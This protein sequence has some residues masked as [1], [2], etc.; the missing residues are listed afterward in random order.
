[1]FCCVDSKLFFDLISELRKKIVQLLGVSVY[2]PPLYI[3]ETS[4]LA[5]SHFPLISGNFEVKLSL[6]ETIDQ[7]AGSTGR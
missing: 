7:K 2:S 1:M 5:S 4:L 3:G 6:Y